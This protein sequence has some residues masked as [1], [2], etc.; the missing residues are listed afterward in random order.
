MTPLVGTVSLSRRSPRSPLSLKAFGLLTVLLAA[1]YEPSP[2]AFKSQLH[3]CDALRTLN[4]HFSSD[5]F[6]FQPLHGLR[7]LYVIHHIA[8]GIY[9]ASPLADGHSPL[10]PF[11]PLTQCVISYNTHTAVQGL[12]SHLPEV[13]P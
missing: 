11:R 7:C 10:T 8:C 13:A 4:C 6:A 2:P 9:L 3:P 1:P 5:L 12:H